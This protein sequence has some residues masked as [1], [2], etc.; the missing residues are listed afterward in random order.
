MNENPKKLE[1]LL[2]T[3]EILQKKQ[4][5]FSKEIFHLRT[6]IYRLK[7]TASQDSD[8]PQSLNAQGEP[9]KM[10]RV[11]QEDEN[12][13]V[14]Y[15]PGKGA[16]NHIEETDS[17]SEQFQEE[18]FSLEKF[19]GENLINKI[20]IGIT[21][22][23]VSLGVKYTIDHDLISP[24]V[25]ILLGYLAGIVLLIFGIRLKSQYMNY[26]AVLVSGSMAIL[27]FIS[28][29][30]YTFYE[31]LPQPVAFII[32]VSI[33]AGT[34]FA[35]LKFDRQ[36]IA[37]IGLVGA[38]AIPYL[39]S[40]DPTQAAVLFTYVA[41][42]NLGILAISIKK[43]W[44]PLHFSSFILTWIIY[45]TWY[46]SQNRF[47][48]DYEL[49]FMFLT[50]FFT[51]FYVT[52]LV[53]KV[54]KKEKLDLPDILLLLSN[55]WVFY[56][57]G[58]SILKYQPDWEWALGLF[59]ILNALIH[60]AVLTLISSRNLPDRNLFYFI[61]GMVLV[62]VTI[63]IPVQLDSYWVTLLFAGEAALL[64]WIGK[65]K[66][67]FVYE[68]LSYP[69]MVLMTYSLLSDWSNCYYYKEQ[70]EDA[71]RI[72]P[73]FN[74]FFLTSLLAVGSIGFIY[75]ISI[76]DEH[77]STLA[78]KEDLVTLASYFIPSSFLILLYFSF[79]NEIYLYWNQLYEASRTTI[80][81]KDG[82]IS[83]PIFNGDLLLYKTVWLENYSLFFLTILSLVNIH[84]IKNQVLGY[85]NLIFST[86][87]ICFYLFLTFY[88]LGVLRDNYLGNTE[89][90]VYPHSSF[91]LWIRYISLAFFGTLLYSCYKNTRQGILNFDL[92]I[93]F[94]LF[95]H[96]SLVWIL[97][98]ELVT[99]MNI[100]GSAQSYK[101]GLSILWGVYSLFLI[102]L[103][104]WKMKKH[105]RIGA[106]ALFTATLG[107]LFFY[108]LKE[109]ST[110]SKTI[111]FVSL[112]VLLLIISFLYN[113]YKNIISD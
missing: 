4:E 96:L 52:F 71:V 109:L 103:G 42:I 14:D 73:L 51:I 25:R 23:G 59:T 101:L 55:F 11:Q 74:P 107:K 17:Q 66:Q 72:I 62:F 90:H 1:K 88:I 108:D 57:L 44:E 18:S 13:Q 34:V 43:F 70:L 93:H 97:S 112:G 21:V 105:L 47:N 24:L 12:E 98:T 95:L 37:H 77:P 45:L 10:D 67:S 26:S 8:A 87:A 80:T 38:Y 16:Q 35:A 7:A 41:I 58:Y 46:T 82:L 92:R 69:L 78:G 102:S 81:Y 111:V 100:G 75:L 79:R 61:Q 3:L 30:A 85:A 68:L 50:I 27:Y 2:E 84:K 39:L 91:N 9:D 64:Y 5:M 113:K 40:D 54:T 86:I 65:T 22:I 99:W 110:M 53:Y 28:Y 60:F 104:I 31:L 83:G 29:A 36:V 49:A 56:G 89:N 94:D 76:D 19:I 106:I 48:R 6:E 32:M 20:G 15:T 33:T 63:A